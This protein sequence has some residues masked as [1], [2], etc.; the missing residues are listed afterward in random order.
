VQGVLQCPFCKGPGFYKA[1]QTFCKR[2]QMKLWTN[3]TGF[4]LHEQTFFK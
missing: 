2:L 1:M 3:Y 4:R